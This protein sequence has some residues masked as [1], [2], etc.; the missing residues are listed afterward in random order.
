M[1]YDHYLICIGSVFTL[2]IS[3]QS[4]FQRTPWISKTALFCRRKYLNRAS[5][6]HRPLWKSPEPSR[7]VQTGSTVPLTAGKTS[8]SHERHSAIWVQQI[9]GPT[10]NT[11][12]TKREAPFHSPPLPH[13]KP[14]PGGTI[15]RPGSPEETF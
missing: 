7:P 14:K 15:V 2:K 5:V 4:L 3:D 8:L 12:L 11:K 6:P 13:F 1:W 9:S 10:R